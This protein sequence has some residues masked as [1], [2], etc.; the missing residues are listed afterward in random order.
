MG[1]LGAGFIPEIVNAYG[2]LR[3]SMRMQMDRGYGEERLLALI[4]YGSFIVFLSFLP[5]LFATDLSNTPDQSIAGGVIMWFFVVM[6][7]FP[8]VLYGLGAV[9]HLIAKGFGAKGP[10]FNARHALFWMLAVLSP[11]LISKA[12]LTSVF[13]QIGGGLETVGL[14]ALNGI[15]AF[16]ILR[17]WGAFLAESEGFG[18][19]LRVSLGLLAVIGVLFG[20]IFIVTLF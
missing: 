9:S 8:L 17:I 3:A 2:G 11:V 7:F 16:A 15:L 10:F 1:F 6:F 14:A 5:R 4:F 19:T 18:S 13:L 20:G 12:L